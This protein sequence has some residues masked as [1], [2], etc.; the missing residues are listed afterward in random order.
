MLI[1]TKIAHL[2]F[3]LFFA[4]SFGQN[5]F[6]KIDSV[7]HTVNY[8]GDLNQLIFDLIKNLDN[9][10]DKTRAI[11]S[12]ITDNISYDY[13]LFNKGR[14]SIKL[15]CKNKNDCEIKRKEHE[16]KIIEKVLRKRKGICSGYSLLFKR[17][18]ELAK[19]TC[20]SI[21]GYV[22]TNS[23]H[24]GNTGILDHAWNAVIIDG[25]TYF[26][27][28]T[29]AS[30]YCKKD[31]NK[32]LKNFVKK[33]NDFYWFTPADK[34]TIDHFP[35]NPEK[36]LNFDIP[37]DDYKNQPY[38][39]NS[40]IPFIEIG[41][42]KQGVIITKVNDSIVF[43]F[44]YSKEI[45]KLQINTNLKRNPK[46]YSTNKKGEKV[47]NQKAFDKQEYIDFEKANDD[48]IFSYKIEKE[49]LRYIEILFDYNLKL[50]Y[51]IKI[52]QN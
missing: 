47:F 43:K 6:Q 3:V 20:I 41:N 5:N 50:K 34:F 17:M 48:Y 7:A 35:K 36:V 52:E 26:L 32:K 22:K 9:E 15:K 27:D 1:K 28:L 4:F 12:W 38:I 11:Y 14:K 39:E 10:I 51:L 37:K 13:K 49:N 24:V 30:G 16:N 2:F 33:K 29:W 8:K 18:C 31:E 23:R 40:I 42:P 44:K 19:I 46:F 21:D 45:K 25:Q